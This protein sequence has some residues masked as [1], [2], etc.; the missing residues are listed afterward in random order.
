VSVGMAGRY[1]KGS[2]RDRLQDHASGQTVNLLR[3]ARVGHTRLGR[4]QCVA[5]D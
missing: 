5:A 2:E 3:W 4:A 1:G